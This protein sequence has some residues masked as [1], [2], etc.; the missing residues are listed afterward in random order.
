MNNAWRILA[1]Y[2]GIGAPPEE[3]QNPSVGHG[4]FTSPGRDIRLMTATP[5]GTNPAQQPLTGQQPNQSSQQQAPQQPI[6]QAP[7]IQQSQSGQAPGLQKQLPLSNQ[8]PSIMRNQKPVDSHSMALDAKPGVSRST[9]NSGP[10]PGLSR[11]PNANAADKPN[12]WEKASE[13]LEEA[14]WSKMPEPDDS[15]VPPIR[16]SVNGMEDMLQPPLSHAPQIFQVDVKPKST[17]DENDWLD[18]ITGNPR[19]TSK[20]HN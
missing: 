12:S 14:N 19:R 20:I 15:M 4:N 16:N 9:S 18:M 6:G 10:S 11:A 7:G 2:V 13:A 5:F 8:Q 1:E 17:D 3:D